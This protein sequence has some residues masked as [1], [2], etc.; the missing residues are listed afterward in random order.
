[1]PTWLTL[2]KFSL[3]TCTFGAKEKFHV[4]AERLFE[5]LA[6]VRELLLDFRYLLAQSGDLFF[7]R[8]ETV[9]VGV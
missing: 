2:L 4:C 1:M 9:G 8:S 7:Q 6:E 5:L 3:D